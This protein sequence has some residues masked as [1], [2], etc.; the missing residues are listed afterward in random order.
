MVV[1]L[2]TEC[3]PSE[4]ELAH[5]TNHDGV[6]GGGGWWES[7]DARQLCAPCTILYGSRCNVKDIVMEHADRDFRVC[8]LFSS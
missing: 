4:T 2:K 3:G 5:V 6:R 7:G 1:L 8:E